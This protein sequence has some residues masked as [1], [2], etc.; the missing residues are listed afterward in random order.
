MPEAVRKRAARKKKVVTEEPEGQDGFEKLT[1]K[2]SKVLVTNCGDIATC[3]ADKAKQGDVA[4]TKYL[5]ELAAQKKQSKRKK[6]KGACD[7]CKEK[8]WQECAARTTEDSE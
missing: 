5:V 7:F 4:S 3:L 6:G 1:D 2:A 8:K